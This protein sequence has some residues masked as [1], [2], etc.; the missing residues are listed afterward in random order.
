MSRVSKVA[1]CA[2]RSALLGL[3]ADHDHAE[4]SGQLTLFVLD[5]ETSCRPTLVQYRADTD[6]LAHRR[7]PQISVGPVGE[8]HPQPVAEMLLQGGV[9][10]SERGLLWASVI[11]LALWRVGAVAF[12]A[13][14][15]SGQYP[16]FDVSGSE[17]VHLD[18]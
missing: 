3:A 5:H 15:W 16:P 8:P 10:G 7:F 17:V 2:S 4:T 9:V 1:C 12:L 18:A 11:L 6:D 13:Y 14:E